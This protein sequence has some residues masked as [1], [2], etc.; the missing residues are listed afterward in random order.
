MCFWTDRSVSECFEMLEIILSS[1]GM[2]GYK[3]KSAESTHKM[4][5][6]YC[7]FFFS[8]F[9]CLLCLAHCSLLDL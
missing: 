3:N 4:L 6:L 1:F 7:L 8:F 2:S 5:F 9:R